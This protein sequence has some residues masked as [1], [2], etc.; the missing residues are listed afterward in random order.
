[1]KNFQIYN[2][3]LYYCVWQLILNEI[4]ENCYK[5]ATDRSG[6]CVLQACVEHSHG[7][8]RN[9][10]I[11]EIINNAVHIAEDPFG[12]ASP[13]PFVCMI[14]FYSRDVIKLTF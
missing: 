8:V 3:D 5:V 4:A 7:E 6:C 2:S 10:L 13:I 1:M 12:F 14:N 9:R 11:S